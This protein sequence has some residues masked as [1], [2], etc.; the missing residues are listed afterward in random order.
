MGWRDLYMAFN[1]RLA[2]TLSGGVSTMECA[3]LFALLALL[4]FPGLHATPQ[5]LVQWF[6][7]TFIQLVMLA[8]ISVQQ[9][10]MSDMQASHTAAIHDLHESHR[11]LHQKF[12]DHIAHKATRA[13]KGKIT[14]P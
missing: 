11:T 10:I 4:G 9:R 8:V 13:R 2:L 12:D 5:Q 14:S 3:Y 7:Q 1:R 6:S